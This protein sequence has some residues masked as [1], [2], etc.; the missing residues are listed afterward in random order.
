MNANIKRRPSRCSAA[1]RSVAARAAATQTASIE[2]CASST[3][4][5]P[6]SSLQQDEHALVR[7]QDSEQANVIFAVDCKTLTR[8]SGLSRPRIVA[9]RASR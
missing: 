7:T 1:G 6:P 9:I 8:K 3:R 2:L 5:W 4:C